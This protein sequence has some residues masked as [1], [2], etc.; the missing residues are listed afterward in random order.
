MQD[1][2]VNNGNTGVQD[3]Q[4]TKTKATP[5]AV[6]VSPELPSNPRRCLLDHSTFL[7]I[8]LDLETNQQEGQGSQKQ[9]NQ[10]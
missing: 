8:S 6:C 2:S 1:T 3:H 4:S 7:F 10:I 9:K 5:I